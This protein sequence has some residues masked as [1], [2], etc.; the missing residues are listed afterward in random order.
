MSWPE[1]S[2]QLLVYS[3]VLVNLASENDAQGGIRSRSHFFPKMDASVIL[4]SVLSQ[5]KP[6]P[7]PRII[8]LAFLLLGIDEVAVQVEEPFTILPL[9]VCSPHCFPTV[10]TSVP[11]PPSDLHY[12]RTPSAQLMDTH[13]LLPIR[14]LGSPDMARQH[15]P[16]FNFDSTPQTPKSTTKPN[17]TSIPPPPPP[18]SICTLA[19]CS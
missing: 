12:W 6:P 13:P 16:P 9:E 2:D 17:H 11:F 18:S 15:L 10:F 4:L 1:A 19:G 5:R 8:F 14:P 3:R 7:C